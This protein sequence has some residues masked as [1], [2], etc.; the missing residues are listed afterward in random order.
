V[1]GEARRLKLRAHEIRALELRKCKIRPLELGVA[2]IGPLELRESEIRSLELRDREI[3]SLELRDREIRP[4][5]PRAEEVR[6]LEL[7]A[8]VFPYTDPKTDRETRGAFGSALAPEVGIAQ[9][10]SSQVCPLKVSG[11]EVRLPQN[12]ADQHRTFEMTGTE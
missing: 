1:G 7:R 2:E 11:G 6:P 4:L 10:R 5:E 12:S 3:R 8:G 9:V